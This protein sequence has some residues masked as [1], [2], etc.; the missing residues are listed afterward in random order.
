MVGDSVGI[1]EDGVAEG[2]SVGAVLGASVGAVLGVSVV[3][4]QLGVL[5][6]ATL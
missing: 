4:R 2:E 1:K 3:G 5:V 6:G